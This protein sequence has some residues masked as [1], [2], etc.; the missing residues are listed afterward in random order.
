MALINFVANYEDLSTDRGYQF[1][2]FCDKCRNGYMSLF[3]PS[4]MGIRMIAG[5]MISHFDLP[6]IGSLLDLMLTDLR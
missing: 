1:K 4:K 2:F 3:I 5:I 6:N